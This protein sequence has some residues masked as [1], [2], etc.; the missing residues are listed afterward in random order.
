VKRPNFLVIVADDL[1]F[2]RHRRIRLGRSTTPQTWT[3]WPTRVSGSPIFIS[4]AGLLTDQVDAAYRN[5]TTTSPASATMLE[6]VV[7]P[8]VYKGA[9]PAYEGYLNDRGRGNC[10]SYSWR[11]AGYLTA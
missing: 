6:E 4:A 8:G 9:R 2:L 1:G 10:P 3:G 11:D 7:P 5:R